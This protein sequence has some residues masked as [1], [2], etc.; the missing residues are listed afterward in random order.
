M[1][2]NRARL[3]KGGAVVWIV[4]AAVYLAVEKLAAANVKGHYSYLHHY[5]SV[6]GVPAWGRFAWLM[7]GAFY[8]QGALMLVGAALLTRAS[9]RRGV[10]FLLL[11]TAATVGYFLVA[12]VH[13]GSP[14]AKGEGMQLHMTGALL[15]FIAGNFA[16]IAGSGIVAR[17]VGARWWYRLVSLLIAATGIVAFLMLAN[18]NLWTYRYAPVGIVERVPVY[19][20]LAWQVFSAAVALGLLR[21]RDVHVEH[22]SV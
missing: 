19:S 17:A 11:T 21:K 12:T 2:T 20:I 9:G 1:T 8:L 15:V 10:F 16:I 14:L 18:Y 6:L 22:A 7:N 4:A 5:I 13:G 3:V